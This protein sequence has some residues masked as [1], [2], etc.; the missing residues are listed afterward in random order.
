MNIIFG[1]WIATLISR[2]CVMHALIAITFTYLVMKYLPSNYAKII[3]IL[4]NFSYNSFSQ[5][6][7]L[8]N[9]YME[10]YFDWGVVHM[11][12]TLRLVMFA[13]DVS[14]GKLKEEELH[15]RHAKTYRLERFPSYIEVLG[16]CFFF[17][18]LI[19]GPVF[20]MKEYLDFIYDNFHKGEKRPRGATRQGLLRFLVGS[21]WLPFLALSGYLPIFL[22]TEES[23]L[24]YPLWKRIVIHFI[25]CFLFKPMYYYAWLLSE[26]SHIISGFG[27]KG[28]VTNPKTG[29]LEPEWTRACN[30]KIRNIEFPENVSSVALSWNIGVSRF[31][32][33]YCYT[34][35]L[36]AG[37]KN[38][39]TIITYIVSAFWHGF[40]PGYYCFFFF[41]PIAMKLEAF[42]YKH[43]R[44]LFLEKDGVTEKSY[45]WIYS[46]GKK[47]CTY[48]AV[49]YTLGSFLTLSWEH[50]IKSYMSV[51][52]YGHII[53]I[54]VCLLSII[55]TFF[56][57]TNKKKVE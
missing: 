40:Y 10:F 3:V 16:Y 38:S 15:H 13:F 35:L 17:P 18:S 47:I 49:T 11:L 6:Q 12:L 14:D 42:G 43:I 5:I 48:F 19:A 36:H 41:A 25:S 50:T 23:F 39:A 29:E 52:F 33:Y 8:Y 54:L 7:R 55:F 53:L 57:K 51:Y 26:G 21:L 37:Y 56:S 32:K 45:Y 30:I 44:P 46:I 28:Y 22:S 31:L 1:M 34:R 27:F 4:F 9:H 20:P 2:T 24:Q